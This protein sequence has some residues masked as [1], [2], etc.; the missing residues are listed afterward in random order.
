[1]RKSI[2]FYLIFWCMSLLKKCL[3]LT[4]LMVF[5]FCT[6][7]A[8]KFSLGAKAGALASWCSFAD[9][10]DQHNF[11]SSPKFGFSLE[12]LINFPMKSKTHFRRREDFLCTGEECL[13]PAEHG[14]IIP[15][16]ILEI[17]P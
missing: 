2:R 16:I 12:G 7:E 6:T 10:D 8:Q 5:L 15:H 17:Y 13:L 11:S 14:K 1:M 3:I 4:V 9:P